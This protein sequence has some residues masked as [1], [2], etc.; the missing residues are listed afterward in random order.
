MLAANPSSDADLRLAG[1]LTLNSDPKLALTYLS[2]A[3]ALRPS[4]RN[5]L[6]MARA[7]QRTGD[8]EKAKELLERARSRAPRD[9]DVVRAV[10][11]LLSGHR[12]I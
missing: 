6:L 11:G 2:K 8:Q 9:P 4:A 10:A 5:E 7:Y 3:D 1:E 12:P